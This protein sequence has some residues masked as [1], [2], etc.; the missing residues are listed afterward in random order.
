M[1]KSKTNLKAEKIDKIILFV[2]DDKQEA[3]YATSKF[4]NG[5]LVVRFSNYNHTLKKYVVDYCY[6]FNK[7]ES[8]KFV[9]LLSKNKSDFL[10][11]LQKKFNTSSAC[12]DLIKYADDNKINYKFIPK[13]CGEN[14]RRYEFGDVILYEDILYDKNQN[15]IVPSFYTHPKKGIMEVYFPN[16]DLLL[17]TTYKDGKKNG[18]TKCYFQNSKQVDWEQNYTDDKLDGITKSYLKDGKLYR[19]ETFVK[20]VKEGLEKQYNKDGYLEQEIMYKNNKKN[21]VAIQYYS[22]GQIEH[23]THFKDGKQDGA[24]KLYYE[25]GKLKHE[26]KYK[27]GKPVGWGITYYENG[28]VMWECPHGRTKGNETRY[29]ENGNI[30]FT[31]ESIGEKRDGKF[32]DYYENGKIKRTGLYKNNKRVGQ[33]VSYYENGKIKKESTLKNNKLCGTARLYYPNGKLKKEYE[34]KNDKDNGIQKYFFRSGALKFEHSYKDGLRDGYSI[35]YEE[36][37]GKIKYKV[38]YRKGELIDYD[39]NDGITGVKNLKAKCD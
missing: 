29:Y 28:N 27:N 34:F 36:K 13:Y 24:T 31:I 30:E 15:V 14:I 21:G 16:G 8:N 4:I 5:E 25:S 37:T 23:K 35:G 20:G 1:T 9:K 33:I 11:K 26:G 18:M 38:L 19:E 12:V 7:K 3:K 32:T 39:D 22:N 2:G 6:I 10:Y 17:S